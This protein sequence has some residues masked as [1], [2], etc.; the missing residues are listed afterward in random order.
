MY[1][2]LN[3][4]NHSLWAECNRRSE[5]NRFDFSF[6]FL[7]L[8]AISRLYRDQS[9]LLFTHTWVE[10]CLMHTI[11]WVVKCKQPCP[12]LNLGCYIH[13]LRW[14]PIHYECQRVRVCVCVCVCVCMHEYIYVCVCVWERAYIFIFIY[15]CVCVCVCV[16]LAVVFMPC[17][18][19][20]FK[21]VIMLKKNDPTNISFYLCIQIS[22]QIKPE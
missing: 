12:G 9:T 14:R 21:F 22:P 3:L 15:K 16:F 2:Y 17:S 1:V 19:I 13:F 11:S 10:N 6:L 5:F 7:R 8:V 20:L 18:N 4:P